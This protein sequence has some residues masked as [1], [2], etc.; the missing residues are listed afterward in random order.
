MNKIQTKKPRSD[1]VF[2]FYTNINSKNKIISKGKTKFAKPAV[3]E[4]CPIKNLKLGNAI[5]PR[6]NCEIAVPQVL[7]CQRPCAPSKDMITGKS[8]SKLTKVWLSDIFAVTNS[9]PPNLKKYNA[10]ITNKKMLKKR[11]NSPD[12][13][14][15]SSILF[16]S[17]KTNSIFYIY[18]TK[19]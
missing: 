18:Y 8:R 6:V 12:L 11:F 16:S 19:K 14:L 5:S 7:L 10:V 1:E 2:E 13:R 15:I 9:C 17:P 4:R 3:N